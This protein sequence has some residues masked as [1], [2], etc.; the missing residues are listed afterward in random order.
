MKKF[1]INCQFDNTMAP[2]TVYI[3]T[4]DPNQHPLYFQSNWLSKDRGGTIPSEVMEAIA[5]LQKLS[6]KNNVP[7]EDLCVYALN[8]NG[9]GDQDEGDRDQDDEESDTEEE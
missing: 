8:D 2:F 1:S 3:G 9:G 6:V 7:L 4:P 5:D